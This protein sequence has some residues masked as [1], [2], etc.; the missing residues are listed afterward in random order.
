MIRLEFMLFHWRLS[1]G[2]CQLKEAVMFKKILVPLDGSQLATNALSPAL[3]L[4]K[5]TDGLVLLLRVPV[6]QKQ[7]LPAQVTAVYNRLRPPEEKSWVRQRAERY[8]RSVRQMALGRDIAFE[9]LVIDGDPAGVIVDTAEAQG[10]DLIVM[11]THGRSGL[12]RWWLGSVTEKVLRAATRPLLIVSSDRLPTR[13]LVTLDGSTAAEAALE[14][15]RYVAGA[16]GTPLHLLR[17]LE[18][19]ELAED[20]PDVSAQEAAEL[21]NQVEAARQE[22]AVAYLAAIKER[23]A[24]EEETVETAVVAGPPAPAILDYVEKQ[25]IDLVVMSSHGQS[26]EAR[27]AYGSVTEKVIHAAERAVLVVR[28]STPAAD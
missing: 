15:A 12:A 24:E 25:Q 9:T 4:A 11:S 8:L 20:S 10:V 23:L 21:H 7:T 16:F 17:V 1:M 18:P 26:A 6:Y 22:E 27:W 28:P 3:A 5:S 2:N 19:L 13:T 14:P